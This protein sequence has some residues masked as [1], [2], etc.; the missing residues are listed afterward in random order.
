MPEQSEIYSHHAQEYERL[1]VKE[2]YKGNLLPAIQALCSVEELI[3]ADIGSGT[4]RFIRMLQPYT[5]WIFGLDISIPMLNVAKKHLFQQPISNW[6]L[7]AADNR[8]LPLCSD[9]V[10]FAISGW[11]YG[12]AT[13]WY[14]DRWRE[15]IEPSVQELLRIVRPGGT[16]MIFETMGT[17]VDEP[18]PPTKTLKA[19]YAFLVQEFGF[20]QSILET[21]YRFD[22]L[23]EAEEV[24]RFFFGDEMGDKVRERNW[25]ILPEWTGMWWL[26]KS[27]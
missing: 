21:D 5:K 19:Y 14:E 17:G 23:Q 12:H 25:V 2:D 3:V 9:S 11:S 16:A 6:C 8:S 7:A 4:G 27:A 24:S 18:G 13:V 20:K 1:I 26:K 22:S 10:D 15:E